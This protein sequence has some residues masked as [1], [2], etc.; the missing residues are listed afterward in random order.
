MENK[1]VV[2]MMKKIVIEKN[3]YLLSNLV[4]EPQQ[5]KQ[6]CASENIR[7]TKRLA[8]IVRVFVAT[9]KFDCL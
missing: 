1:F 8:L 9:R 4:V 6:C 2:L 5:L 3:C 7:T